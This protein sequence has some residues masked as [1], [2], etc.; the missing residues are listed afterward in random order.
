MS[1]MGGRDLRKGYYV[2]F[3][4]L[5]QRCR[6]IV[7]KQRQESTEIRA[8]GIGLFFSITN[9]LSLDSVIL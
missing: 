3:N 5:L 9:T 4:I 2:Y 1:S 6:A 8:K 7:T